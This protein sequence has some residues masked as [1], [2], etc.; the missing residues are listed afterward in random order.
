VGDLVMAT[1]KK[2]RRDKEKKKPCT[3]QWQ[4]KENHLEEKMAC[5]FVLKT[6]QG[7]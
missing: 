4:F 7:S 5:V 6:M 2:V 1:V 3:Q